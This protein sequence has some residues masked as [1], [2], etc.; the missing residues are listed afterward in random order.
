MMPHLSRVLKDCLG[1]DGKPI[2]SKSTWVISLEMSL[3]LIAPYLYSPSQYTECHLFEL[4]KRFRVSG[5]IK[6]VLIACLRRTPLSNPEF[7]LLDA[8]L[9]L[10]DGPDRTDEAEVLLNECRERFGQSD[11]IERTIVEATVLLHALSISQSSAIRAIEQAYLNLV[12]SQQE[13]GFDLP[14]GIFFVFGKPS[15]ALIETL[16]ELPA[17][18][19]SSEQIDSD[20]AVRFAECIGSCISSSRMV[21]DLS[22]QALLA[23]LF[24]RHQCSAA[25]LQDITQVTPDSEIFEF[26]LR[27]VLK[28]LKENF[29]DDESKTLKWLEWLKSV[30]AHGYEEVCDELILREEREHEDQQLGTKQSLRFYQAQKIRELIQFPAQLL[31]RAESNL[32]R[33]IREFGSGDHLAKFWLPFESLVPEWQNDATF[34]MS[35][36]RL[37]L[38]CDEQKQAQFLVLLLGCVRRRP[39][40]AIEF[41]ESILGRLEELGVEEPVDWMENESESA[42][43]RRFLLQAI[44]HRTGNSLVDASDVIRIAAKIF[45]EDAEVKSSCINLV[46]QSTHSAAHPSLL[47]A[48]AK[49]LAD[50]WPGDHGV[51]Q[52]IVA[53]GLGSQI[54]ATQSWFPWVLFWESE[55]GHA[56]LPDCESEFQRVPIELGSV[57]GALHICS[58]EDLKRGLPGNLAGM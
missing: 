12:D 1:G 34:V 43:V 35:T 58:R 42:I 7:R 18:L 51:L 17:K 4:K 32:V 52:S 57:R 36:S 15:S 13:R 41:T 16:C 29:W 3:R 11:C 53:A 25:M 48:A 56:W 14:L 47:E 46:V 21:D 38:P 44:K 23:R 49:A 26:T 10:L 2:S 6:Q 5:T 31:S 45:H 50:G 24:D 30:D 54:A 20:A 40:E 19:Q 8:L 22:K 33:A 55:G 37:A 27:S 28:T 9:F 39:V